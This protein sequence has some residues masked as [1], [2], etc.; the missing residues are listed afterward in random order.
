MLAHPRTTASLSDGGAHVGTV[1]DA[2]YSNYTL[3]HGHR[4]RHRG[5][6]RPLEEVVRRQSS[7]TADLYG[8]RDRGRIE[9]GKKADMLVRESAAIGRFRDPT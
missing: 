1:C 7:E 8:L 5:A 4:D 3:T 2:S 9:V 6:R